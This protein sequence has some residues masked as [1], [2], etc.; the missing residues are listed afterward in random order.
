MYFI[1]QAI[2]TSLQDSYTSLEEVI[3][4]LIGNTVIQRM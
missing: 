3:L 1:E 2:L 4:F